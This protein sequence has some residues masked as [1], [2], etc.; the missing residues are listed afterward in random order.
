[1]TESDEEDQSIEIG[2]LQVVPF[3]DNPL[4][5]I[6]PTVGVVDGTA[7][8]G[9]W[10]PCM[11]KDKNGNVSNRDLL[12]L[13][14]SNREKVLANDV[15]LQKRRWQ[16]G[17]KPIHFG[18]RWTLSDVKA[19]LNGEG[20]D[21]GNVYAKVV[22]CFKEFIEFSDPRLYDL[23]SLYAIGTYFHVLFSTFPYLYVGGVK[24]SGKTKTLRLH[25][26]LDF[27]AVFSNNMSVSSI[28]RIIQNHKAT[29]LIDETEKLSNPNRAL[30]FRNILLSGFQQ[31]TKVYRVE[32]GLKDRLEP[33]AFEVYGPKLLANIGGLEDVLEDRC[34][35]T[36]QK[37]SLNKAI[38]NREVDI[39]D[40]RFSELRNELTRL[41]LLHWKEIH[42]IYHEINQ[43][44]ELGEL[45]ELAKT[46]TEEGFEYLTSRELELW[47]PIFTL[48]LFFD[49][50][51]SIFN[52]SLSSQ[53]HL[54]QTVFSLA[55]SQAAQRHTENMTET[56]EEI[57]IQTLLGIVKEGQL[58]N[59]IKVKEIKAEISKQFEECQLWLSSR[60]IGLA[61]R[62]LGFSNKRRVG[63]GYEYEIRYDV[64]VDLA[65]R[66]QIP[67]P[68]EQPLETPQG[69]LFQKCYLCNKPI[70]TA[71]WVADEFTENKPSHRECF[72]KQ[73]S[74]VKTP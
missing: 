44:S 57:L 61:L 10:I 39:Q 37:R 38:T 2:D 67:Q 21:A 62:R 23:H 50:K 16:L 3:L 60:W 52:S 63:T 6:H 1:M 40:K 4:T 15:E 66:M 48:A 34:I 12:W 55:C 56:G 54:T 42:D 24:R 11:V 31:G 74:M 35:M 9:V 71:D 43:C 45:C 69:S 22:G 17:Y 13:V 64:L 32:K 18:N 41:F 36:F 33:E 20:V 68:K 27:N 47:K 65:K 19:F 25:S 46:K 72:E 53:V 70:V 7:Y 26:C 49:R 28:Y 5:S 8:V 51:N 73:K 14:T 58:T 59:W 30:E 29:L